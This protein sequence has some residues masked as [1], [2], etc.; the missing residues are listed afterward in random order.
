[1]DYESAVRV[2]LVSFFGERPI[3][4]ITADD[5]ERLWRWRPSRSSALS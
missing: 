1:M 2:H 4:K 5:I 3:A